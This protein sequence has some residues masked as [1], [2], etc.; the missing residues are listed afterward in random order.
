MAKAVLLSK[1]FEAISRQDWVKAQAVAGQIVE[2]EDHA[3]HYTAARV[4]RGALRAN[5]HRTTTD[6]MV[7]AAQPLL[8][9]TA[10]TSLATDIR[11]N[12]VE[13][14]V[15]TRSELLALV[16]EWKHARTLAKHGLRRRSR[17]LFHG[18]P[19]CGKTLTARALAGELGVPAYV[20]R[21]DAI[22]GAYLGQTAMRIRELFQFAETTPS[23]LVIDEI[24]ALGKKRGNP[25]D[26]GELDRVVI[27]L[28]QQ[29]EHGDPQGLI[30]GA[31]NNARELDHA[32]WR[33]FDA[34]LEFPEPT[35]A[36]LRRFSGR[37]ARRHGIELGRNLIGQAKT[38]AEAERCVEAYARKRLLSKMRNGS[39]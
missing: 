37:C 13:L 31:A 4:L 12:A 14:T 16:D 1:L 36:E 8:T 5:G 20:V 33:R 34:V 24:D 35:P 21:F 22:V 27:A 32:L 39:R 2:G 10:L 17:V 30:I 18:P 9:S 26:V 25:M 38:Y 3:R 29:L 28:M 15:G 11:L 7:S 19:G 6:P 23:V